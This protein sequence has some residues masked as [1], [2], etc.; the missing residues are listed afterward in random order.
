MLKIIIFFLGGGGWEIKPLLCTLPSRVGAMCFWGLLCLKNKVNALPC[1]LLSCL[2]TS[3]RWLTLLP[4]PREGVTW[5]GL[6]V[7]DRQA[8]SSPSLAA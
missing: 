7:R 1:N 6:G 8:E 5:Q 2:C 4:A 3:G